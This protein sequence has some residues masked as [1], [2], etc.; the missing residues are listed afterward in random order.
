MKEFD[1]HQLMEEIAAGN[2]R[3]LHILYLRFADF[4]YRTAHRFLCDEEE[5]RDITQ[6]VFVSVMQAADKYSPKAKLTTWFYRIAIN[7]CL[8]YQR[9]AENTLRENPKPEDPFW[10]QLTAPEH[11]RPD[12]LCEQRE[13]LAQVQQ[14]LLQL[15][16]RQRIAVILSRF[17]G[18]RY[19]EIAEVMGCSKSSVESILFRA[20]QAL[21]KFF[22]D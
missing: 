7:H 4:V 22:C 8:N 18:M 17:E 21:L 12:R 14:A 19:E 20:R 11:D 10:D 6:S 16:E 13:V 15:P 9:R 3:A 1:D 2:R 5:A